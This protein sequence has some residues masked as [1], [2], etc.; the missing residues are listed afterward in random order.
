VVAMSFIEFVMYVFFIRSGFSI[1]NSF[2]FQ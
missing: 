1:T 2:P